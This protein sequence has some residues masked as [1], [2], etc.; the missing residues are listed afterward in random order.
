MR[1][2]TLITTLLAL[3][4]AACGSDE[5]APRAQDARTQDAEAISHSD[6]MSGRQLSAEDYRSYLDAR[7]VAELAFLAKRP[8]N[9]MDLVLDYH[10]NVVLA[11]H[12]RE[13]KLYE[14]PRVRELM[15]QAERK[16]LLAALAEHVRQQ[17]QMPDAEQIDM[18]AR[19]QYDRGSEKYV[20]PER[21]IVAHILLNKNS[22]T[23]EG[24]TP[25]ELA[26]QLKAELDAGADFEALVREHSADVQTREKG[27]VIAAPIQEDGKTVRAFEEAVFSM[28]VG[29]ISAPVGTPFGIHLIKLVEVI[30]SEPI[31]YTEL[32][33]TLVQQERQ[34]VV[35]SALEEMRAQAYP[36]PE[37][38]DLAALTAVIE[39]L[40]ERKRAD[41]SAESGQSA[42]PEGA[43]T[44]TGTDMAPAEDNSP[45]T[46]Q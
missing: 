3:L 29:D 8:E 17:V 23:L 35:N 5:T 12:A 16:V 37:A 43:E 45:E 30:P 34:R 4:L 22:C 6:P 36:D 19:D 20:R 41:L 33:E 40:V 27:G 1:T 10:S 9:Q 11:E 42:Q 21:R 18:L 28:E 46:E 39:G 13:L 2:T 26:K 31:P 14:D 24:Q 32:E 7:G 38:I 25:Q 44:D 15:A